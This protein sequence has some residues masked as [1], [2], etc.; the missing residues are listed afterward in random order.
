MTVTLASLPVPPAITAWSRSK[1]APSMT[2]VAV[3]SAGMHSTARDGDASGVP[4]LSV[5]HCVGQIELVWNSPLTHRVGVAAQV[6]RVVAVT[7]LSV[8]QSVAVTF[9]KATVNS[10]T[11]LL[12]HVLRP[13]GWCRS[14]VAQS[15]PFQLLG[16]VE[17]PS[18]GMI[19]VD[20]VRQ[21]GRRY[22]P[23]HAG[24]HRYCQ[25]ATHHPGV[26]HQSFSVFSQTWMPA[27]DVPTCVRFG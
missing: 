7:E 4:L 17:T 22:K 5:S 9:V 19:P 24:Q 16:I 23:Q 27:G 10:A 21:S 25:S 14:S 20:V 3:L 1:L 8:S 11:R 26:L 2:S 15:P 12:I 6:E 18:S 13:G